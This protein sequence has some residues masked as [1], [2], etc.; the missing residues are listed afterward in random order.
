MYFAISLFREYEE[1]IEYLGVGDCVGV[2]EFENG[3]AMTLF[4]NRIEE[5]DNQVIQKMISLS[6][7]L[8]IPY[9][10]TR[11]YVNPVLLENRNLRNKQ[12]YAL[13]LTLDCIDGVI[14]RKW[15]KNKVK[16]MACLTDG[17]YQLMEFNPTWKEVDLLNHMEMNIEEAFQSLY[18]AQEADSNCLQHPR[19]KKRDDTTGVFAK[20]KQED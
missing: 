12:F 14:Y 4:D 15:N 6:K 19:L 10:Q 13:D 18:L 8:K 7:E 11:P 20:R 3:D 9:L 1:S 2:I 16:R 17:L 5:M